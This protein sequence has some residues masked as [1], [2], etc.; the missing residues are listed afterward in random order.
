MTMSA[1]DIRTI[2]SIVRTTP[3]DFR[4][5][6]PWRIS[7]VCA[8]EEPLCRAA[9]HP[10]AHRA[11][12]LDM[13]QT[14]T[15]TWPYVVRLGSGSGHPSRRQCLSQQSD[16]GGPLSGHRR[17]NA[18]RCLGAVV[19]VLDQCVV[20]SS[21]LQ[22]P[23][24]SASSTRSP[25][26][27]DLRRRPQPADSG[28][29]THPSR[30]RSKSKT[31]ARLLVIIR[32]SA[33]TLAPRRSRS[34]GALER[35]F[36]AVHETASARRQRLPKVRECEL[37]DDLDGDAA[38]CLLAAS[39]KAW[40][41]RSM[42]TSSALNVCSTRLS[43]RLRRLRMEGDETLVQLVRQPGSARC[44]GWGPVSANRAPRSS[45][46]WRRPTGRSSTTRGCSDIRDTRIRLE[47]QDARTRQ[48]PH[49]ARCVKGMS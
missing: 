38:P 19:G 17:A 25:G 11:A 28:S 18:E 43:R 31:T 27:T 14:S 45:A 24:G 3:A 37:G 39:G 22:S 40:F 10:P 47:A 34:T 6:S 15:N 5:H 1:S 12:K 20:R 2:D 9:A 4:R 32:R 30:L 33:P 36:D 21:R 8:H 16:P 7:T 29:R 41:A 23:G 26:H 48:R 13:L 49:P 44:H 42:E 35:S 46:Q